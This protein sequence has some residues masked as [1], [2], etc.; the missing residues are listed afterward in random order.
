M[1]TLVIALFIVEA[2][3]L[4]TLVYTD[5]GIWGA[6]SLVVAGIF[7]TV[8]VGS[9]PFLTLWATILSNPLA[10]LLVVL[11]YLCIGVLWSFFKYYSY[12]REQKRNGYS[13]ERLAGADNTAR[14]ITWM[15]YWPLSIILHA[16]GDGLYKLYLWMYDQVKNVYTW[17]LDKVYG[18]DTPPKT[19]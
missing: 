10:A 15:A 18:D 1:V 8:V 6:F 2:L 13:K 12:V 11:S 16:V 3:V 14:V 7:Y 5:H 4:S 17:I 19:T 9:A